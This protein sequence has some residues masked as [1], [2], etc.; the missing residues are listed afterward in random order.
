MLQRVEQLA[1]CYLRV[2]GMTGCQ[3]K[4]EDSREPD[5]CIAKGGYQ[6]RTRGIGA[7][8]SL[9]PKNDVNV[10]RGSRRKHRNCLVARTLCH[11]VTPSVDRK[12]LHAAFSTLRVLHMDVECSSPE[13]PADCVLLPCSRNARVNL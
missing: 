2:R 9:L 1:G 7:L 11:A 13:S 6:V 12:F 10:M 3:C 4:R 8:S 5:R